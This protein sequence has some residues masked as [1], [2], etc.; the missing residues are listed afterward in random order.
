M[1]KAIVLGAGLSGIGASKLL[2]KNNVE[3]LLF[4]NNPKLSL[5]KIKK[6]I[7]GKA[8]LKIKLGS[9]DD[10]ELDDIKLC[11]ISPGFPKDNSVYQ[12]IL[13]KKIPV[14][15]EI[16]LAY[17]YTKGEICAITGSN[18]KTTTVELTAEMLKSK[19]GDKAHKVGNIGIPYSDSVI[20]KDESDKYVIECSSFQLE[21]IVNF[22]PHV[23][24]ILNIVPDHLDRYPKYTDYINAKLNIAINMTKD[25]ILILNYEDQI[26]RELVLQKE[27]F[28][29]KTV[30]FS[31]RRT[32]TEGFYMVDNAIF[33]KDQ[34]KTIK[35]LNIDEIKL[36]G[37]HNYENVMAAM[38]VSYYMGVSLVDVVDVAKSFMGLEHRIEFVREKNGVKYYND[39]KA[40]NPDATI[41]AID[42]I[43]GKIIL[44]AGGRDKGIDYGDLIIAMKEKV[45]YTILYGEAKK[46]IAYKA[47]DLNYNNIIYA[48]SLEE[49]VDMAH[50]Y[51]NVGDTVL[52]S[53]ACSSFDMYSGYE[54]RGRAFKE[55]VMSLK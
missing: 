39:S 55:K 50:N 6:K 22:R 27:L 13:S 17:L 7:Y 24:A 31:S 36:I 40:T 14:I 30:F 23:A 19:Y 38:A 5:D 34:T 41:K 4:D 46:K 10:K 37:N 21:D 43:K 2:I 33:F 25:D 26:L 47:K 12:K 53:P 18:G 8:K 29:C 42:A 54:E 1:D 52:L 35:L 28:K 44:I 15:S 49:A 16:E 45:R 11:V 3:V 32:L 48:D 20:G 9:I 51:S